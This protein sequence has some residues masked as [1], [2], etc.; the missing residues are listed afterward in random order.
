MVNDKG[1]NTINTSCFI[2]CIQVSNNPKTKHIFI[3]ISTKWNDF[4]NDMLNH[5]TSQNINIK[6]D[7]KLN[8]NL[9]FKPKLVYTKVGSKNVRYYLWN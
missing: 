7:K 4:D 6:L 1:L 2:C 9:V 5:G 8:E 3:T